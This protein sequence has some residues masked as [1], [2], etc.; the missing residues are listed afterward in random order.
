MA[1]GGQVGEIG[2]TCP[3]L[4]LDE[5]CADPD[6]TMWR[7]Q[8]QFWADYQDAPDPSNGEW[9]VTD[10]FYAEHEDDFVSDYAATNVVEDVAESFMTFVLEDRP[11]GDSVIAAKLDFF[12]SVPE[13]VAIRE[14]I[15]AEFAV[16]LGLTP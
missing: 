3:T 10:A 2:G 14:R 7:F 15:R 8:Q 4:E 1:D 6:S 12:W 5:G 16:D 11:S 13:Y 9:E